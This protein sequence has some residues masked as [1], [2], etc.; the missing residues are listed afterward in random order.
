MVIGSLIPNFATKFGLNKLLLLFFFGLLDSLS[1]FVMPF[2]T[3][4]ALLILI[5]TM[6]G[7][8]GGF[9]DAAVQKGV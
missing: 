4:I 5:A 2:V 3:Q 7:I 9:I 1:L 8:V 6:N